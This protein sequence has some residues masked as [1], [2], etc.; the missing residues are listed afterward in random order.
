MKKTGIGLAEIKIYHTSNGNEIMSVI[1]PR[2]DLSFDSYDYSGFALDQR[3]G[4]RRY[5]LKAKLWPKK[6]TFDQNGFGFSTT[7]VVAQAFH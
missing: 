5:L 2:Y 7:T 1:Q 4:W 6:N 3:I